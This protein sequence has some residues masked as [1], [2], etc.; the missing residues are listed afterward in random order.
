MR[1]QPFFLVIDTE[2]TGLFDFSRPADAPGQ[3]R[4]ASFAMLACT[5]ELELVAATSVLIKPDGWEMPAEASRIHGLSQ[6]LLLRHGAPVQEVLWRYAEEIRW[7]SV[8]A[9]HNVDYD[10]KVLR[11]EF[12]R[13]GMPD[14]FEETRTFCT[15]RGLTDVCRIPKVS[16][17]G[18]KWPRLSEAVRHCLGRDHA[19]AH[20]AL[21]DAM[22]CLDLLRWMKAQGF[23][24]RPAREPVHA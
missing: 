13:A 8:I 1:E 10:A 16:G 12:R 18:Y 22:A 3:P 20:G 14:L 15:M 19:N 2:T 17:R 7:G 23:A 24:I 4:L 21:P 6:E 9:G 5:H 11:G